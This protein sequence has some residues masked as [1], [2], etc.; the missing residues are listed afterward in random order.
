MAEIQLSVPDIRCGGCASSIE[1][2]LGKLGGVQ[3]VTVD[4]QA[5]TVAVGFDDSIVTPTQIASRLAQAG[6]PVAG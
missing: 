4:V 3:I 6:F 1:R 5:R 2:S